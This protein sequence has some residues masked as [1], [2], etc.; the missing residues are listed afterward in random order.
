MCAKIVI[1]NCECR[2]LTSA[3]PLTNDESKDAVWKEQ[4]T[5]FNKKVEAKCGAGAKPEDFPLDLG[6]PVC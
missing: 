3:H 4:M 6:L 1:D 2:H 5:E